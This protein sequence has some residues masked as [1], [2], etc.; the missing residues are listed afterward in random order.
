MRLKTVQKAVQLFWGKISV[1]LEN[2]KREVAAKFEIARGA[3]PPAP[4]DLERETAR[5]RWTETVDDKYAALFRAAMRK[6]G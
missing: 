1:Y 3:Q 2:L 6:S 5:Q 4:S